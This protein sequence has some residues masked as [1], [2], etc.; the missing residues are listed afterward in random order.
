[1][2]NEEQQMAI[3]VNVYL[4]PTQSQKMIRKMETHL[5]RQVQ[6]ITNYNNEHQGSLPIEIENNHTWSEGQA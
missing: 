2:N 1:M 3:E 5:V 6:L 4:V